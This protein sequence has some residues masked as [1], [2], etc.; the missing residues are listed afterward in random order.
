MSTLQDSDFFTDQKENASLSIE[1][2]E[3]IIKQLANGKTNRVNVCY[4]KNL[5]TA[6]TRRAVEEICDTLNFEGDFLTVV[7]QLNL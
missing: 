5:A 2:I 1:E 6:K 7:Y 4:D 3:Q